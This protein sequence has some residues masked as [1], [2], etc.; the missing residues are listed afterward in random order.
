MRVVKI[1]YTEEMPKEQHE[2][3]KSIFSWLYVKQS[4]L[5]ADLQAQLIRIMNNSKEGE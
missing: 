5:P 4:K 1:S 2:K 3:L